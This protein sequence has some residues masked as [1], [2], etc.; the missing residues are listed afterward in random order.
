[1]S[2]DERQVMRFLKEMEDTE[3][4]YSVIS[5]LCEN[6]GYSNDD[7]IDGT[8]LEDMSLKELNKLYDDLEE[9]T[10]DSM[11]PNGHDDGEDLC[12]DR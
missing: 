11:Y 6:Y 2:K 12:E 7:N 4:K 8:K 5:M 9:E 3:D 10:E 1:M